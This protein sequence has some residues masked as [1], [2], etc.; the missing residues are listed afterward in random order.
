[1]TSSSPRRA[2][3]LGAVPD[4]RPPCSGSRGDGAMRVYVLKADDD[5]S[6][7]NHPA[8]LT[9]GSASTVHPSVPYAFTGHGYPTWSAGLSLFNPFH[10]SHFNHCGRY[11][12]LCLVL[13]GCLPSL[14]RPPD[15]ARSPPQQ[16]KR[17]VLLVGGA[18]GLVFAGLVA[19]EAV[20]KR[21][22]ASG[23]LAW[24]SVSRS[25]RWRD[26]LPASK[27]VCVWAWPIAHR[28]Q[29]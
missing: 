3:A 14:T 11:L 16:N 4:D 28:V 24:L 8:Y 21:I 19:A 17:L 7:S 25:S 9:T 23:V 1:M 5:F 27:R 26:R 13:P 29:S 2:C 22:P 15:T 6:E 18:R 20:P 12:S 10:H